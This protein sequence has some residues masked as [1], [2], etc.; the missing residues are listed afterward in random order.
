MTD[1]EQERQ[2]Q[3]KIYAATLPKLHGR[4][5]QETQTTLG[6]LEKEETD[7]RG[8]VAKAEAANQDNQDR[9]TNYMGT[10]GAVTAFPPVAVLLESGRLLA[11]RTADG[12]WGAWDTATGNPLPFHRPPKDLS[13]YEHTQTPA[14][15]FLR[16]D[17]LHQ[18]EQDLGVPQDLSVSSH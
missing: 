1:K 17:E 13:A 12:S 16:M 2:N 5:K 11:V 4:A 18:V 6:R 10:F 14:E 7:Q 3:E 15:D 9:M 8:E